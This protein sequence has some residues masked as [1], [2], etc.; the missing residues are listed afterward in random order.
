[1][2]SVEKADMPHVDQDRPVRSQKALSAEPCFHITE[3]FIA[4]IRSSVVV[5]KE[6]RYLALL[7]LD[8]ENVL[9]LDHHIACVGD[10]GI[11]QVFFP[12]LLDGLAHHP[13]K[14]LLQVVFEQIPNRVHLITERSILHIL[15]DKDQ[16]DLWIGSSQLRG[17][18]NA[19]RA[20][21]IDVQ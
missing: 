12:H 20:M 18:F 5:L 19:V 11:P 8:I 13:V 10:N 3:R 15:R 9:K 21:Q 4:I 1:M 16:H 2:G 14:S 7:S 17:D 6:V